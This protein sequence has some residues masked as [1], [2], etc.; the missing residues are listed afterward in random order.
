MNSLV[1]NSTSVKVPLKNRLTRHEWR[2]MALMFGIILLLHVIGISLMWKATKGQYQLSD[3]SMFGWG[4]AVLAYTLGMR[5]AF[6]ADHIAAIDNTTRKLMSEGQRPLAVGFFFSLGHSSVVAALAILLNFG[7]KSLGTQLKDDNSSLHHYTGLI[8]TSI[9]GAFLMLIAILNL[10]VLWG[11]IRIFIDMRR[12]LYDEAE[13]EKHLNSRG[14]LMRF[15]GPIA[16]RI[17]KSWK[18]YPLGILFGLG[19]DTATEIGLLVL[20]G[21][22]VIA[23]L[24]WWAI[25]ALPALFAGG[26]SLLDTI[27]GSFMNFAYG[28]AFSKPVRKVYYNIIITGL[29]V[30]AAMF[31]GGM[32]LAQVFSGQLQLTGGFWD[33][34]NSFNLNSAG[35]FLV[36][37]FVVVWVIA[38]SVWRYGKIEQRW[39]DRAHLAQLARGDQI[40]H[41][42]AGL[43]MGPVREPFVID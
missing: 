6:D 2:R 12:G 17:D 38:I 31:I 43:E 42:A 28:W 21:S 19:F 26:M 29:S 39:H 41:A 32:E 30:A 9:S 20:A 8:G 34:A 1:T 13:L 37:G 15:F 36:A 35:Y 18:M 27:D 33:Y 11:V 7:I 23:G 40:N 10:V 16:R 25:I 3:G 5:H 14:L 24:P 4:T 22:S